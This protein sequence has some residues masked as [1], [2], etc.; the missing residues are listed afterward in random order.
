MFFCVL[1]QGWIFYRRTGASSS[2]AADPRHGN[3]GGRTLPV[4]CR[5]RSHWCYCHIH[6]CPAHRPG[7]M[8]PDPPAMHK[9]SRLQSGSPFR[10][11]GAKGYYWKKV[12]KYF[13]FIFSWTLVYVLTIN[14]LIFVNIQ[15]PCRGPQPPGLLG[16]GRPAPALPPRRGPHTHR[17]VEGLSVH[18]QTQWG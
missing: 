3:T 12:C 18:C 7:C 11:L 10:I 14:Q 15:I 17:L 5:R 4:C 9:S 13:S 8:G 6:T 2:W 16:P 1:L